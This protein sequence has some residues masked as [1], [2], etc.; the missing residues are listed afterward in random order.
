MDDKELTQEF[1]L[2]DI[3]KEFAAEPEA[4]PPVEEETQTSEEPA[5][6]VPEDTAVF[7]PAKGSA[8]P[9]STDEPTKVIGPV[10]TDTVRLDSI[11]DAT[12]ASP[13]LAETQRFEPIE[14]QPDPVPSSL[15]EADADPEPFTGQWE[16]QYEQPMGEYIPPQPIIFRPKSRLRELKRKLIAGPEKRYYELTEVGTGKLQAAIFLTLLISVLS[17]GVTVFHGLGLVQPERMKLMIFWQFFSI[18]ISALLGCY[19]MMDGAADIFR[20]RFSLNS[21]L[22]FT[23]IIC[24]VDSVLCLQ[25]QRIPCCAAFSLQVTM[26]LL[27]TY[28]KRTTE[29]AQMDTMRR[30]VRLD[31]LSKKEA[32][33]EETSGILRSEGQVEDFMDTYAQRS[34]PEKLVSV[35]ALIAL[36]ISIG[37]GVTAYFLQGLD[38]AF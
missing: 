17:A 37:I 11:S 22:L 25:A 27:S 35:Y 36:L 2:D 4:V 1:D 12:P 10:T 31:K 16:P 23:F 9:V 19:Q 18:L 32:F 20:G 21:L 30:A 3:M 13:D 34:R 14:A 33:F 26:S 7:T 28:H 24:C 15:P 29:I 6:A 5:E 38:S 8:D